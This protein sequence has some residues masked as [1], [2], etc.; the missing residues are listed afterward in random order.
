MFYKNLRKK[1]IVMG[2]ST[3]GELWRPLKEKEED[4][5]SSSVERVA[6]AHTF[7]LVDLIKGSYLIQTSRSWI[8]LLV[9]NQQLCHKYVT[10]P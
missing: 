10:W 3:S 8:S 2:R 6:R 9:S 7:L 4:K 5:W 1:N